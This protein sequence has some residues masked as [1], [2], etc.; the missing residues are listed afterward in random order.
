[1]LINIC[2]EKIITSMD[3]VLK[4]LGFNS[5]FK[6]I[7]PLQSPTISHWSEILMPVQLVGD[8]ALVVSSARVFVPGISL[9]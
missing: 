9:P 4:G 7:R 3:Q 2:K 5:K 6:K 8:V 1:M